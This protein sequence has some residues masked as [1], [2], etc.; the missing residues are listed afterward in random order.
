MNSPMLGRVGAQTP[1]YDTGPQGLTTAGPEVIELYRRSGR[2]LDPWQRYCM[3]RMCQER[4]DGKWA[5]LE[6][7]CIVP[8]QNGKGDIITARQIAGLFLF[9]S[10]LSLYSAHEFKT[11]TEM[12][13]RLKEVID[14]SDDLRRRIKRISEANGEEGIE[15]LNGNR[16]RFI[17]RSRGSGRGFTGT[18]IYL[19]ESFKLS[20]A[21]VG[22]IMPTMSAMSITGNPQIMYFS[23]APHLDSEQLRKILKRGREGLAKRLCYLEWCTRNP[24]ASYDDLESWYDA[25]PALGI[26]IAEEFVRTELESMEENEFA[27]ERLGIVEELDAL[28]TVVDMDMWSE[29]ADPMSK[30]TGRI[31][32]AADITPERSWGSI[33]FCGRRKDGL[34]H[35][36]IHR[37][38]R[39][40]GWMLAEIRR[41]CRRKDVIGVVIDDKSP[42]S[43]LIAD[44]EQGDGKKIEPVTVFRTT[45]QDMATACGYFYDGVQ[46]T[47]ES[48]PTV[49]HIGQAPLTTAL[50]GAEKRT[51]GTAGAW[52]WD[53]RNP[54]VDITPLVSVTLALWGRIVHANHNLGG[55]EP[56]VSV[57]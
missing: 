39:G 5:A 35:V 44:L 1:V 2:D 28:E 56:W 54:S 8:R 11:A 19:D 38:S 10:K 13:L 23:S 53:R 15:L 14:N 30:R 16:L 18:D 40:V 17:A 47:E 34:W 50:A 7:A 9:G 49:R 3:N 22:A 31:M 21:A 6:T 26:R 29:L 4:P 37:H 52:A 42:A 57:V 46:V 25:N 45:T 33:A 36:E 32:I 12:F 27:R 43:T 24:K 55:A 51:I 41:L 20:A 48:L